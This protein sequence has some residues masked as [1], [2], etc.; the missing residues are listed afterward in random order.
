MKYIAV[1]SGGNCIRVCLKEPPFY[2]LD[3][4]YQHP[5][6]AAASSPGVHRPFRLCEWRCAYQRSSAASPSLL[7]QH[8]RDR[9]Q[10]LH[11][12]RVQCR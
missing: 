11:G 9:L 8:H 10:R 4:Q 7:G 3:L 1:S 6:A 12:Q 5:R 2:I